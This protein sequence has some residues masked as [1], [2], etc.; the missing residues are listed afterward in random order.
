MDI[1]AEAPVVAR[2]EIEVAARPEVV[3][4]LLADIA[5]WP[6]W[7]PDIRA[8][9]VQGALAE[10]TRFRWK[11]GPGTIAST[12]QNLAPPSRIVWTGT[13]LGLQAIHVYELAPRGGG[14]HVTTRESME[15]ALVRLLPGLM[16]SMLQKGL[17][18]G[19]RH[20]KREAE[21]LTTAGS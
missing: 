6:R 7:N 3:F 14:T 16:R 5:A 20:L 10:G 17:D 21:R 8:A 19:L 2:A 1:N 15:G 18:G 9:A 11:S 4:G 12:V 13:T